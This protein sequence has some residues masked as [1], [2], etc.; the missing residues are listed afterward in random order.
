MNNTLN[1]ISKSY[2]QFKFSNLKIA[3]KDE[4]TSL[5][6]ENNRITDTEGFGKLLSQ[7][8]TFERIE[9]LEFRQN[10]FTPI[11]SNCIRDGIIHKNELRTLDLGE[12]GISDD[13]INAIAQ[14]LKTHVR[15]HMLFIDNNEITEKGA[16]AIA[17]CLKNKQDLRVL[18]L[19]N[20]SI[21]PGGAKLIAE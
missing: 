12:N 16:A 1:Y 19:D 21:G 2:S 8:K 13:G 9:K 17:E 5:T 18:N 7:L 6:L 3:A 4:L 14:G 20:N 15:L 11:M 10:G